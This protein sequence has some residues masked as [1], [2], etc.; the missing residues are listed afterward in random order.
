MKY[1]IASFATLL[2]TASLAQEVIST[3]GDSYANASGS[4]DFTIGEVIINTVSDGTNDLTQGFHQTQWNFV[5]LENYYP[6]VLASVYPN[7]TEGFLNIQTPNFEGAL[8]F[9]YDERGRMVAEGSLDNEITL[10]S[11]KHL[12]PGAYELL[13]LKANGN[14]LKRFKL[15]K[16]N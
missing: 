13:L 10:F 14:K 16:H 15:I 3:Q 9:M 12:L 2:L 6:D 4:I 11:V 8:Y 7:P 5:G 1:Y